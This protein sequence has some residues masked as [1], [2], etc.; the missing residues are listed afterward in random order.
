MKKLYRKDFISIVIIMLVLTGAFFYA[1]IL[2]GKETNQQLATATIASLPRIITAFGD[3]EA[4]NQTTLTFLNPGRVTYLGFREGDRVAGGQIIASLDTTILSHNITAAEAQYRSAQAVLN[5]VLDDIHLF[6]YGNG[7]FANVGTGNETQTQKTQRQQAEEAVNVAF[8]SLQNTKKQ[9][10][11]STIIAPYDG[12]IF[13]IQN[14]SEGVNVTPSSASLITLIGGGN[15]RFVANVLEQD[16]NNL[17]QGQLVTI[18]LDGRKDLNLRGT[19]SKIAP[20][21][22]ILSD[23]RV[24][25][26][27]DIQSDDLQTQVLAG[28][29][30][31]IEIQVN[32]PSVVSVPSWIVLANKYIWV[33]KHGQAVLQEVSVGR[34]GGGKIQILKG[35]NTDDQIIFDPE[36]IVRSRYKLP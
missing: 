9:L 28:Q 3:V 35:L 2:K 19:I 10:D 16:I 13:S 5:K 17:T 24:V 31:S 29:T 15:L 30:G 7:G 14:I 32:Q 36:L 11:F 4:Q 21:K 26:K 6:Q 25:Y 20:S 34:T 22:T 18:K 1:R 23:G 27:V 8:D 33:I 12:T